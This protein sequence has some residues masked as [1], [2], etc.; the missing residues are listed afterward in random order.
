MAN[1]D[2]VKEFKEIE[3]RINADSA[4]N[5]DITGLLRKKIKLLRIC[6]NQISDAMDSGVFDEVAPNYAKAIA[7][8]NNI[9]ELQTQINEDPSETDTEIKKMHKR[10]RDNGLGWL[11]DNLPQKVE[12]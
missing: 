3:D 5:K 7:F 12:E 10:M 8:L 4:Q 2:I 1:I 11:L 6:Y 9:K